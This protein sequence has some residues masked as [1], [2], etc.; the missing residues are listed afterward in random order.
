MNMGLFRK[1]WKL[2]EAA[3]NK[4]YNK[5]CMTS[6]DTDQPVRPLSTARVFIYPSLDSPE[7][8]EGT[9]DQQSL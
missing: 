1:G 6:R 5:I 9:C 8:V 7:A 4:T 2:Y 3:D